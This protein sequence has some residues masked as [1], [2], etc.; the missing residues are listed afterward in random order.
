MRRFAALA[1]TAASLAAPAGAS[2]QDEEGVF[3]DDSPAGQDYSIPSEQARDPVTPGSASPG[4]PGP[5]DPS[6]PL[7]GEGVS[8]NP[9]AASGRANGG[10]G[11]GS[12]GGRG[13]G[14]GRTSGG[15]GLPATGAPGS[16]PLAL[17]PAEERERAESIEAAS[18]DSSASLWSGAIALAIV[19]SAGLL[20]LVIRRGRRGGAPEMGLDAG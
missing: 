1:L 20:A 15:G 6:P 16:P 9:S 11:D 7:F 5:R 2:A 14:G 8:P 13:S 12:A 18:A 17:T 10:R 4:R 3:G 19:L